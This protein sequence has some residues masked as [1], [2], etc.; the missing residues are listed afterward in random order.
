[1]GV[2]SEKPCRGTGLC[3]KLPHLPPGTGALPQVGTWEALRHSVLHRIL[4]GDAPEQGCPALSEGL[5]QH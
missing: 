2:G 3:R 1:M 5:S 4:G